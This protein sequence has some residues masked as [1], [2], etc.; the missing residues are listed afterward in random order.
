LAS[1]L[2]TK[3]KKKTVTKTLGMAA[4]TDGA[5]TLTLKPTNVLGKAITIAYSSDAIFEASTLVASKL[6][7]KGVAVTMPHAAQ[8]EV[9]R[10]RAIVSRS[11]SE[12]MGCD[13]SLVLRICVETDGGEYN[14]SVLCAGLNERA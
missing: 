1:E 3:K 8:T 11:A 2:L 10:R 12:E 9:L 5:G 6:S 14:S 7:K 4:V 13:P